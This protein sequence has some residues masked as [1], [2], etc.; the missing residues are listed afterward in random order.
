MKSDQ[1]GREEAESKETM[2][3]HNELKTITN[4]VDINHRLLT[5]LYK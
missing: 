2:N 5:Y 3:K 1:K 4:M